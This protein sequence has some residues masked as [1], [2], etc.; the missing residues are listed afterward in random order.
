MSQGTSWVILVVAGVLEAVWAV[1][2]KYTEG[3]TRL[4]PSVLV[5]IAI[6]ASMGLLGVAARNLPISTAYPVW[7]GIGTVGA[8]VF[9]MVVLKEPASVMK[10]AFLA[11]LIGAIIGLKVTSPSE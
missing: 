2:L 11:L 8:V 1:G 7:V 10:L 6:V 4:V 3:F 9:G 5:A